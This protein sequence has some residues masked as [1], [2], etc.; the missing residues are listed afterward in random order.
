MAPIPAWPPPSSWRMPAR[1][2]SLSRRSAFS[3]PTWAASIV[4][5]YMKTFA[6][7][8]VRITTMTRVRALARHGNRI[9]AILWSPY[10][11]A[12][13]GE[14]IVDQVVVENATAPLADLYFELKERSVEPRRDRLSGLDRGRAA[15][16]S[17]PTRMASSSSSASATPS[18]PATSTPRSTTRTG[19][20]GPFEA[21]LFALDP[22]E[23]GHFNRRIPR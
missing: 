2:S 5:P 20:R 14:R 6:A 18:P 15:G 19:W 13:C 21:R 23:I 12:D 3:R 7:R 1:G 16:R 22:S 11:E 4:V 8:G 17:G 10:S 9:K